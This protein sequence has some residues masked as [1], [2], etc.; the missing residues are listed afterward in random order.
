[1]LQLLHLLS[2]QILTR[3][4][5][6]AHDIAEDFLVIDLFINSLTHQ[7]H[8]KLLDL[9][10]LWRHSFDTN[11]NLIMRY[12]MQI[13]I[14]NLVVIVNMRSRL[15]PFVQIFRHP[16]LFFVVEAVFDLDNFAF[17][18]VVFARIIVNIAFETLDVAVCFDDICLAGFACVLGA[19]V[20]RALEILS[21][22]QTIILVLGWRILAD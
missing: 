3:I 12:L 15:V 6:I 20:R 18:A 16:F 4:K 1:M 9:W 14:G 7:R 21:H 5:T 17:D 11:K 19:G 2:L 10:Q 8:H 22:S 13:L